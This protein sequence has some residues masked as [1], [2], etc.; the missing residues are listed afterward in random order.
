MDQAATVV[1]ALKGEKLKDASQWTPWFT[2]LK[3][4]AKD[5]DVWDYI[6]PTTP[7]NQLPPLKQRPVDPGLPPTG[8]NVTETQRRD[9]RDYQDYYKTAYASYQDQ[10]RALAAVNEWIVV[11][12]D[13]G[14]GRGLTENDWA[15][16]S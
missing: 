5:R 16:N 3:T 11:N 7:E 10:R 6:D 15:N 4:Y 1:S 8:E 12:L 2:R 9:W 14:S 13:T